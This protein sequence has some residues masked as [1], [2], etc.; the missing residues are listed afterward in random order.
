MITWWWIPFTMFVVFMILSERNRKSIVFTWLFQI[1]VYISFQVCLFKCSLITTATRLAK[2]RLH[3]VSWM[4]MI[5]FCISIPLLLERRHYTNQTTVE[6]A[7]TVRAWKTCVTGASR[8]QG[9]KNTEFEWQLR[10][11]GFCDGGNK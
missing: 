6:Q 2:Q 3:W 9:C 8:L 5:V 11:K 10:E 7:D 4:W 1:N